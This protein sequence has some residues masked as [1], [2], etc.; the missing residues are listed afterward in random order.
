MSESIL[1]YCTD[2]EWMAIVCDGNLFDTTG[3][4]I[5][6]LDE[7]QVYTLQGEYVGYISPHGRLLRERVLPYRK[8]RTPPEQRPGFTPPITVP[9]PPLFPELAFSII[10]VF[11]EE[12][13]IFALVG[14]LRPDAGEKPIPRLVDND[15]RLALQEKLR[16]VEQKLLEEMVYGIIFSYGATEP[17]VPIE[18]MAAGKRP[19]TARL[20][21]AS[22]Q[23]R[24]RMSEEMIERLGH[25]TWALTRGYCSPEGFTPA[26]IDYAARA[27]LLP[28]HWLLQTPQDLQHPPILAQRYIVTE[29][30]AMLR[31]H[32]LE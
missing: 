7:N 14:E 27:L 17:P 1:I 23:E 10:D 11:E 3:E 15:P 4:W 16:T 25:S 19:E 8:R 6:W 12:P 9:L 28:R 26:Q 31:I 30:I 22:P 18:A 32:D 21:F 24:Q 5:G 29:E 20:N 2:G 13:D